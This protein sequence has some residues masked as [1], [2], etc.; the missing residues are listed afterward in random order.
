MV[1]INF[2]G[3]VMIG[4]SFHMIGIGVGSTMAKPGAENIFTKVI[5][6][7][8]KADLNVGNFECNFS[9]K[10]DFSPLVLTPY[11]AY[12]PDHVQYLKDAGFHILN[13][14]NNHT[15][16][17]GKEAFLY[18][19][20][21][22]NHH[23]IKTIG[24]ARSPVTIIKIGNIRFAF[25]GYS[26]RPN[27]FRNKNTEYIVGE[28][29]KIVCNIK[30][31]AEEVDHI[32]VSLHWGDEYVDYPNQE[33]RNLARECISAGASLIVGHHP[34]VL[35]GMEY[36]KKGFV[37]YSLG[38]FVFDKPQAL[39]RTSVVLQI[40]F[41][42]ERLEQV[43]ALPICINDAYQP[44]IAQGNRK[45]TI[46]DMIVKLNKKLDHNNFDQLSYEKDIASSIK[47]MRAQFYLFLMF[48]FYRYSPR[49]L[50]YLIR[51]AAKRRFYRLC[52]RKHE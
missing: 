31:L 15:M 24:T 8:E 30:S 23:G 16:Q 36:Y 45:K 2:V 32:I 18:T 4:D 26:L 6:L 39:Q 29:S 14:A 38:N 28:R 33:Q 22:L 17:Y 34:H 41:A 11:L 40:V 52:R 27:Q 48:N 37:A 20:N 7:L 42:K 35:Q 12:S 46:E 21:L 3:D 10:T 51:D 25:L 50:F 1:T 19:E 9:H 49:I 47:S 43:Y 5:P 44:E 13:M